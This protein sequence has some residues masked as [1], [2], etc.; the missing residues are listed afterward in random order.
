MA[1]VTLM[2]RVASPLPCD[3]LGVGTLMAELNTGFDCHVCGARH[4]VLPLSFSVKAP[5]ASSTIPTAERG[6]R[7]VLTPEQCI[8]D[9]C[10]FYLRGRI[11]LRIHELDEP[12]IWGVWAEISPRDFMHIHEH[13]HTPGR[14]AAKPYTGWLNTSLPL[15]GRTLNLA[16]E[17]HTQPVGRRPHFHVTDALHPLARE[18]RDGISLARV[19]EIAA[20]VLHA[21]HATSWTASR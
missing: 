18:Q 11:P 1:R 14:E 5:F 21:D 9:G 17:V 2:A 4:D 20:A 13:W 12:F 3:L 16:V 6:R 19:Q 8:L 7:V 10:R 15:Y